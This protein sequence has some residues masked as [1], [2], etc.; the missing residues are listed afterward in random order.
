MKVV[1]SWLREFAPTELG[2]DDL[3][4]LLVRRGVHIEGILRP[5][6]DLD[7]V[8]VARVVEVTDHPNSEKLCIALV[9]DGAGEHQVVAGIRNMSPGDLVPWAR[10]GSRVPGLP[11]PLGAREL[12]GV[13]SNGMLCSARELAIADLH[14]G[15]LIL[16]DEGLQAGSDLKSELDLDDAVLDIEVEPNRPDFLSV[17]GVAREA[18]AA[19]GV[20]LIPIDAAPD[21]VAE[22]AASVASVEIEDLDGCPRY[23]AR[24]IKGVRVGPS[25]IRVQA[26]LTAS[27]MRP[28]S[29]VVDATNYAMLETGQPLHAFDLFLVKGAGIIVR[30]AA[31]GERLVTLDDVERE[32]TTE[33]L[34][35]A[36]GGR[37]VAIAGVMGGDFAEVS[38]ATQDILL[39]SAHFTRTG[40]LRT[41]RRL[42][43]HTEASVRFERGTDP[44]GV[45]TGA[46][47]GA[48]LIAKWCGGTILAGAAEAG[49]VPARTWVSMRPVKAS[50]LLGY[51]VGAKGAEQVFAQ[52]GFGQRS[53]EDLIEV[54]V[55]GYRVDIEREVDLI[56][57]V[58]R[59][60]GYDKLDSELP[61]VRQAGG[62]PA[63]YAFGHKVRDVLAGAGL[64]EAVLLSFASS[65]D[66]A[67][68]GDDD[69]IEIANPLNAEEGYLR[70]RLITGLLHGVAR[71]QAKGVGSVALFE[72]GTVHRAGDPFE[73]SRKVALVLCGPA[74]SGWSGA[75][76]PFDVLDAKGVIATLMQELGVQD[77]GLGDRLQTPLFH[78]GRSCSLQVSGEDAGVLGELHPRVAEAMDITGRV[79]FAE[80]GLEE[81]RAASVPPASAVFADVPRFPPVRRDLAF[82]V[83]ESVLAGALT[84]ALTE[85]AGPLLS[86]CELF[87]VFR[88][89]SIPSGHKSL[90][91]ALDFRSAHRT[92]TD[93]EVEEVLARI[94]ARLAA[95][96]GAELRAG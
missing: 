73:E 69:A 33:D 67:L 60:Q 21:E 28:V 9:D 38:D 13:V 7:G 29:N 47:R 88:G 37:S 85:E 14:T 80:I 40:V 30:R 90:A 22:L 34:M 12:R 91:F 43:L 96:F 45:A 75:D 4:E 70:T 68:T 89:G 39:E 78:P 95:G 71:N 35:I 59:V 94:V 5:W 19:T 32:L 24:I 65:G 51:E 61:P 79:A 3:A 86:S 56:E 18:A 36:D 55:P 87:D 42:G 1:L 62:E 26:R 15:I 54:E 41:A 81:L 57:E 48:S 50:A 2:A 74:E 17:Y 10:P 8:V 82:V 52:L 11:D 49:A 63:A 83:T 92:L 93:E 31:E 46:D 6:A 58:A 76:R 27:G 16:N 44:E 23:L 53:A 64:R 25:P 84:D 66:L 20:G 77:W 72:V